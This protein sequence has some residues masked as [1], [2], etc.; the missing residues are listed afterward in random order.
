MVVVVVDVDVG[1]VVVG[2]VVVVVGMVVV[3]AKVVT[4]AIGT[5]AVVVVAMQP[6]AIRQMLSELLC[7]SSNRRAKTFTKRK[8]IT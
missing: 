2:V 4:A 1:V 7:N 6:F 8:C 3:V 5:G